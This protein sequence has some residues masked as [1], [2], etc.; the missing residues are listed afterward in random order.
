MGPCLAAQV[1]A[2][3]MTYSE[4]Q[5]KLIAA[6]RSGDVAG[7]QELIAQGFDIDCELKYGATALMLA[8][9]RGQEEVV[10]LLLDAGAKVNRRNRFGA[11]PLLEA[12]EKSHVGVVK[13]LVDAGAEINLPHNNGNTTIFAA[14]F[15]RDRK[16][17]K[18]LLELGADPELANFDGWSAKRWAEAES[19]NQIQAMFGIKKAETDSMNLRVQVNMTEDK[20]SKPSQTG[21]A[22]EGAFWTV[23][24]RAAASGDTDTVR[25]L[26]LD[27]VEVNGQS[28]N[29]TTALIAA[30]K[31][32]HVATA[33]ELI[34]LGADISLADS[35]GIS[36]IEW[37]KKK[38]Q[39]LIV[40]GLE[41]RSV[42][43]EAAPESDPTRVSA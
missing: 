2:M 36:A 6:A 18:A 1:I 34:E 5:K 33:F 27:G 3:G 23:F 41:Q 14:T 16:M 15:R 17:I 9:A 26:A 30:V 29:G 10:R 20:P 21:G 39:A 25:R 11:S 38:G 12:S 28:P 13:M 7:I 35:E 24:M 19:D 31:N 40:Q 8:A 32:G 43:E 37:A 4:E 42:K 22:A